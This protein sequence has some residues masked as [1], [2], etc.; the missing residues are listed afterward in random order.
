[1]SPSLPS[2]CY[3]CARL[4]ARQKEA[5]GDASDMADRGSQ[6]TAPRCVRK[7]SMAIAHEWHKRPTLTD[8]PLEIRLDIYA[9][10]LLDQNASR[11]DAKGYIYPQ[12]ETS[13]FT[14]NKE[15]RREFTVLL[16]GE[17]LRLL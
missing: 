11:F 17:C 4:E 15:I 6:D 14:V 2:M 10:L 9:N 7:A 16:Y 13:L 8:M 1:M 3:L 12:F 5:W